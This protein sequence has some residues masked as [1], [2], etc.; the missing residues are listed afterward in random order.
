[1]KIKIEK[2][3][4][5]GTRVGRPHSPYRE[6]FRQMSK[7]DSILVAQEKSGTL[8]AIARRSGIRVV[9]RAYGDKVRIWHDGE[10]K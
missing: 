1:M 8:A 5:I 10:I 2:N 4:P 6:V 9:T 3:I 7:G